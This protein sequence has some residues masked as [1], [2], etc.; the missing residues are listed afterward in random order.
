MGP[1]LYRQ[2]LKGREGHRVTLARK[3]GWKDIMTSAT[4]IFFSPIFLMFTISV[5]TLLISRLSYGIFLS[6]LMALLSQRIL[7]AA[8]KFLTTC[9]YLVFCIF[10][11][12]S[13]SCIGGSQVFKIFYSISFPSN[14]MLSLPFP[15][16]L[17]HIY[18]VLDLLIFIPLPSSILLHISNSS[19]DLP[20]SLYTK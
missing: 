9:L 13:I 12:T 17:A 18:S 10:F 11:R 14:L 16:V 5:P 7:E 2:W 20:C 4:S 19:P 8:L 1:S 3:M 6:I 15:S